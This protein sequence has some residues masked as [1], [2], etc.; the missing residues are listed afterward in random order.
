MTKD[1]KNRSS[2]EAISRLLKPE[3]LLADDYR[4]EFSPNKKALFQ[5]YKVP[6]IQPRFVKD[7]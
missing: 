4:A 6:K 1:Q 7:F 5:A 2:T 3:S